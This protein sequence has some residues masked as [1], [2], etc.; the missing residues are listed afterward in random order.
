MKGVKGPKS[1]TKFMSERLLHRGIHSQEDGTKHE[2]LPLSVYAT[3]GFD[4]EL[5][6]TKCKD[7][8]EHPVLG[9]CY[10][11]DVFAGSDFRKRERVRETDMA[12]TPA[13]QAAPTAGTGER[14]PKKRKLSDEE[15]ELNKSNA[16]A[17]KGV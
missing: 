1:L 9:L 3:Q 6:R 7:T 13:S 17:E 12:L 15:N 4:V 8:M 2:F 14:P 16:H 10:R 11:L 5:I